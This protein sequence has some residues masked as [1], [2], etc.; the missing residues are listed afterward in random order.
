[1]KFSILVATYNQ[2]QY[3]EE[4][5]KYCISQDFEN[6]EVL[7]S[8]DCSSDQ[9]WTIITSFNNPKIRFFRQNKNI[10]EYEN[11]NFL[12]KQAVGEFVIFI[13]GEDIIYS[14]ALSFIAYFINIMPET[15]ILV[16]RP[17]DEYFIYPYYMNKKSY[18]KNQFLGF[19]RNALNFTQ[20]IFNREA[21]IS[22]GAFDKN[23]IKFGDTYIQIKMGLI[24][25][26]LIIPEGFSWWRRTP[27]QSSEKYLKSYYLFFQ[28]LNKFI[29]DMINQTDLLTMHE[30]RIAL[31][32]FYGNILRF[33]FK[34]I[35]CFEIFKSLKYLFQYKIPFKYLVSILFIPKRSTF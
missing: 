15:K 35:L 32:N 7:I 1:M 13:D 34:K 6:Y 27:G 10:G 17:W 26:V 30:K 16:A 23:D 2:E 29:P 22:T 14:Y 3:I 8:D 20:L 9:T 21:I 33:S 28:E 24:Y 31:F 4:T 18:A 25:G 19:G 11:R 5:I 12:L